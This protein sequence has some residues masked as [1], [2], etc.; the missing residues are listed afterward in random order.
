[1]RF[2]LRLK[3]PASSTSDGKATIFE[4]CS[5]F[6]WKPLQTHFDEMVQNGICTEW[7]DEQ[8]CMP[9]SRR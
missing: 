4:E 7:V 9:H 6:A 1:M 8:T 5:A 2:F 3:I